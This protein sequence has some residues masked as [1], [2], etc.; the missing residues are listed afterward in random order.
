MGR[1]IGVKVR[2]VVIESQ[3][4]DFEQPVKV[5]SIGFEH[6]ECHSDVKDR[7]LPPS[8]QVWNL[9][10]KSAVLERWKLIS[11]TAASDP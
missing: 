9:S 10:R 1:P 4:A 8:K 5:M 2:A 11:D 7:P 6:D 3:G